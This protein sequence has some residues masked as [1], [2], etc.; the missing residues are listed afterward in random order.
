VLHRPIETTGILGNWLFA[1]RAR[2]RWEYFSGTG[3]QSYQLCCAS[4]ARLPE[5]LEGYVA[6]E[7]W[8]KTLEDG[9]RVKFIY[10]ELPEDGAFITAQIAGNEAV[11]SVV[12]TAHSRRCRKSF[13]GRN[14]MEVGAL[15]RG[16]RRTQ[17]A[18]AS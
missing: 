10:Q 1:G 12:L 6:N 11:Y 4:D 8:I 9:G 13:Q 14:F 7:E 5:R 15:K 16:A 18:S 3:L 2:F 17:I